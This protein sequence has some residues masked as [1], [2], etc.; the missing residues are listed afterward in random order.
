MPAQSGNGTLTGGG[1]MR[2][3]VLV[4]HAKSDSDEQTCRFPAVSLSRQLV[5]LDEI[6]GTYQPWEVRR[7]APAAQVAAVANALAATDI[8]EPLRLVKQGERLAIVSGRLRYEAA[9][10][11]RSQGGP[12]RV[13]AEIMP[14]KPA[15]ELLKIAIT[16]GEVRF[17]YSILELGWA[18][19]RLTRL[20][21]TEEGGAPSHKDLA[22][23]LGL[24]YKKWK[25]RISEAISTAER[26]PEAEA[27]ELAERYGCRFV[28]YANQP[29]TVWREL[30]RADREASLAMRHVLVESVAK[31]K[32]VAK[33]LA[34]AR[35]ALKGNDA[36]RN[37]EAAIA[38]N[39][40]VIEALADP[41]TVA[42]SERPPSKHFW[43]SWLFRLVAV[44]K[45]FA[46]SWTEF[47]ARVGAAI[48]RR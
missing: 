23:Y 13:P 43:V 25:S 46:K 33:V 19:V 35:E 16:L 6:D 24:D 38:S 32:P 2:C 15:A 14:Q 21:A 45:R 41:Q 29:R 17:P 9:L 27:A 36:R 48:R 26:L 11:R 7:S 5:R 10:V 44:V 39:T 22:S 37:A 47:Q 28:D 1:K 42:E 30:I 3:A 8:S 31:G 4:D 40:S 34:S 20:L 12:D 18:L